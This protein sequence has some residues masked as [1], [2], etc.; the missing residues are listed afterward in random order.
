MTLIVNIIHCDQF[1]TNSEAQSVS[2]P[3]V[4]GR[5]VVGPAH[6]PSMFLLTEG[7][8]EVR[9]DNGQV[10]THLI[11]GGIAHIYYQDNKVN[12]SITCCKIVATHNL[13]VPLAF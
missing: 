3:A 13:T 1:Y 7:A 12:N 2:L 6:T 10:S 11:K 8:V 4:L 5:M 9:H